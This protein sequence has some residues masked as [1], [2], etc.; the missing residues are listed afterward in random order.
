MQASDM[1][2]ALGR[3]YKVY[4]AGK[5]SLEYMVCG[6]DG[7]QPLVM[8]H[9]LEYPGWPPHDFCE[10]AEASGFQV[11]AVRRPGFGKNPILPD[12]KEQADL[13]AD[14]LLKKGI[15]DAIIVMSG[16][17]CPI[18][19]KL[20]KKQDLAIRNSI[21]VNCCFNY[22]QIAQFQP[23][24]YGKAIQQTL[25]SVA[26]ARLSLMALKSS[27]GIFGRTWVHETALAKSQGDISFLR[28]NPQ[29]VSEAIEN[30]LARLDVHTFHAEIAS[31]VATDPS[32]TD[33]YFEG[34]PA[35]V[36]SGSETT[37][38]WKQG[39]E[40]EAARLGLPAVTYLPS[41][42]FLAV[43]QSHREFFAAL[44]NHV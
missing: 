29:L 17:S 6:G 30:L 40:S 33:R 39:V 22:D 19:Y 24:W 9:S 41:G 15:K 43:Y 1:R 8:I 16:T 12:M 28:E 27:W 25:Q 35:L 11:I 3:A 21:F 14:F 38:T 32:L 36:M 37:A 20:A 44:Q 18:G 34:V 5:Y 10:Q 4:K 26:G 7:P 13:I 2:C 31:S 42:D 23:D